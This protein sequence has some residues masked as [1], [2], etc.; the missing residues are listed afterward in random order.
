MAPTVRGNSPA[1]SAQK[2]KGDKI[3]VE[4]FAYWFNKPQ[5][6]DIIV[7][8]NEWMTST[9]GSPFLMRAAGLPGEKVSVKM[10]KLFVNGYP[11]TKPRVFTRIAYTNPALSDAKY[12]R[13]PDEEYTVPAGHYFVLGDNSERSADSR[14]FGAVPEKNIIGKATKIYWPPE[15]IGVLE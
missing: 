15:R 6:G 12:L 3:L 13:T 8:K 9:R 14:Y 4:K 5:R 1:K 2:Y 10:G 11:V 7:F